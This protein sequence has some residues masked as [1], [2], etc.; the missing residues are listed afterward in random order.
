[1]ASGFV[2]PRRMRRKHQNART[3]GTTHRCDFWY[4]GRQGLGI[5]LKSRLRKPSRDEKSVDAVGPDFKV[6]I[7]RS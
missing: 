7:Q 4:G 6:G 5:M 1:M 2:R 3:N